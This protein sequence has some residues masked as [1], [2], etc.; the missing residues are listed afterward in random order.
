MD[1]DKVI[2]H[3][4]KGNQIGTYPLLDL[5][6]HLNI[7]ISFEKKMLFIQHESQKKYARR[8]IG[9][10]KDVSL[11][12]F[13]EDE[14]FLTF[15]GLRFLDEHK[16]FFQRKFITMRE[17][18]LKEYKELFIIIENKLWKDACVKMG[19]ILEYGLTKWIE[20]KKIPISLLT[21]KKWVKRLEDVTFEEK[22]T[23]YIKTSA[24][25]YNFEL[26]TITEWKVVKNVIKDYRNYIHLQKYEKRINS[27]A[28]L[29]ER[30]FNSV[31]PNFKSLIEL[32]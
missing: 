21:K 22:I 13:E 27:N 2:L 29:S 18:V 14:P 10:A 3:P 15:E 9:Y 32:F 11:T 8:G 1:Q 5:Y 23:Y 28:F 20:S 26:G 4:G 12:F 25:K 6:S 7:D 24:K 17:M 30:D 31:Y 16:S 19:S